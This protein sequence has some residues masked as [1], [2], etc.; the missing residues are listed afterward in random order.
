[1]IET[2]GI[3]GLRADVILQALGDP[4]VPLLEHNNADL[5]S[6]LKTLQ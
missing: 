1:M 4:R 5:L 6:H 3:V 2:V